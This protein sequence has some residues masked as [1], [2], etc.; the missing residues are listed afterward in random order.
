MQASLSTRLVYVLQKADMLMAAQALMQSPRRPRSTLDEALSRT[1][2]LVSEEWS[3]IQAVA[4]ALLAAPDGR[5]DYAQ[6]CEVVRTHE[7]SKEWR[8]PRWD[9]EQR[10]VR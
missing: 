4:E 1:R 3:S 10:L 5:L 8:S 9:D 2:G 7:A 6:T